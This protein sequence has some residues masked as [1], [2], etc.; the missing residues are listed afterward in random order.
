[1]LVRVAGDTI[2]MSPP[3]IISPREVDEVSL[4]ANNKTM[5]QFKHIFCWNLIHCFCFQL[6]SIYGEALKA[7]EERVK[8][9]KAQK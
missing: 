3:F 2:M 4:K 7:T 8:E 5:V 6:I 9:L 1:M